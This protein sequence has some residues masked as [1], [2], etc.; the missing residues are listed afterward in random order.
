MPAEAT[1]YRP[2]KAQDLIIGLAYV[3]IKAADRFYTQTTTRPKEMWQTDLTYF[4]IISWGW[5]YLST[6]LD[7]FS[8]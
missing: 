6:I 8:R 7:D 3:V 5:M 2:L 1:V 4:A